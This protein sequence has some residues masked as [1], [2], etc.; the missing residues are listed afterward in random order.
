V[1]AKYPLK[2][3]RAGRAISSLFSKQPQ[4]MGHIQKRYG[5]RFLKV[6]ECYAYRKNSVRIV[7]LKGVVPMFA[8]GFDLSLLEDARKE[9]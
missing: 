9:P 4:L 8:N 7:D 2:F 1:D 3:F 5:S 6:R